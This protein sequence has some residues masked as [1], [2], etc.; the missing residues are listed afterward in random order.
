M[1]VSV[2]SFRLDHSTRWILVQSDNLW[3]V[4]YTQ[5][6]RSI[7]LFVN[8]EVTLSCLLINRIFDGGGNAFSQYGFERNK[9]GQFFNCPVVHR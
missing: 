6:A 4:V 8:W 3:R 2:L 7:A 5:K 9:T 1:V